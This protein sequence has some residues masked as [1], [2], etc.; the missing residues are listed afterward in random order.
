[1]VVDLIPVGKN[2]RVN[3]GYLRSMTGLDAAEVRREINRA[4]SDGTPIC[5][6]GDGY[7]I[8]ETS[9]EIKNSIRR[10]NARI[11]KQIR[12]RE[13]LR[14][15]I[16]EY[17]TEYVCENCGAEFDKPIRISERY[18]NE[19]TRTQEF[20]GCPVCGQAGFIEKNE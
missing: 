13:G 6:D 9:D 10:I 2:H 12:A 17:S 20:D 7:Y 19:G 1:M 15:A 5:S 11:H 3:T 18:G 14:K 4:R 8:A 16:A